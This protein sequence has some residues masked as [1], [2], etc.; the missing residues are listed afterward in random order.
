MGTLLSYGDIMVPIR[1]EN[2]YNVTNV[3]HLILG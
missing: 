2:P 1:M 3:N